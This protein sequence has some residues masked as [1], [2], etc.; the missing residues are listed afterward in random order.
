LLV[1]G[2]DVGPVR[3]FPLGAVAFAVG[4]PDPVVRL[5][6]LLER[7]RLAQHQIAGPALVLDPDLPLF[8]FLGESHQMGE[9]H[10]DGR[11]DGHPPGPGRSG[12][13]YGRV[14]P[15]DHAVRGKQ[16]EAEPASPGQAQPTGNE[17][18][19]RP[20]LLCDPLVSALGAAG[21]AAARRA[22]R[23]AGHTGTWRCERDP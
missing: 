4:V 6:C 11:G 5:P 18:R 2:V 8:P 20:S 22:G 16:I 3:H 13:R 21:Q 1:I 9:Q 12:G 14:L 15:A 10:D 19:D 23:I 17:Q 7:F